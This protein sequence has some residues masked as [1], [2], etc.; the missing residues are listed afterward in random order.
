MAELTGYR[1]KAI[2][3]LYDDEQMFNVL[4]IADFH[5]EQAVYLGTRRLKSKRVK[6]RILGFIE[7]LEIPSTC[8]FYST[9]MLSL[10]AVIAELEHILELY[11]DIAIDIT[12][13]F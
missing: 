1:P 7:S 4:A 8:F 2:L 12:G 6:N 10:K 11:P 13:G 9:E 5:P 3:E